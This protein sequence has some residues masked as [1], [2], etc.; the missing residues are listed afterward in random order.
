MSPQSTQ[1]RSPRTRATATLLAASLLL[2]P[3]L[4]AGTA[5]LGGDSPEQLIERMRKAS[6]SADFR[7]L[8]ACLAPEPRREL[9]IGI[10][11][12]ATMMIGMAGAMGEMAAG[13]GEGMAEALGAD[14]GKAEAEARAARA[15]MD[16]AVAEWSGRYDQLAA[17]H[18]LPKLADD[19]PEAEPETVFANVD[20]VAVVGDFG[21]LIKGFGDATGEGER[22]P[23]IP[24][25]AL[26]GLEIQ[27]DRAT[28]TLEGQPVSFVRLDG[29]W[30]LAEMPKRAGGEN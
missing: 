15:K 13:M 29:R 5:P 9:A 8:A 18:G 27:G 23:P 1:V 3:A 12:G 22:Q 14:A 2:A 30:Y 25:G 24:A 6:E 7:E 20:A 16:A 19:M 11:L 28:G 10:W 26:Q 21:E 4:G 17:R